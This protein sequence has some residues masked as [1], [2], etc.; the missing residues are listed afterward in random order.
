MLAQSS[1]ADNDGGGDTL[2]NSANVSKRVRE[3]IG[4]TVV[5]QVTNTK[6]RKEHGQLSTNVC[7]QV[8]AALASQNS[9][10]KK[11]LELAQ[12]LAN[13]IATEL[14]QDV[15]RVSA[16]APG[17]VNF[18]IEPAVWQAIEAAHHKQQQRPQPPSS[19]SSQPQAEAPPIAT[20]EDGLLVRLV[21]LLSIET[22]PELFPLM[23]WYNRAA[24]VGRDGACGIR[25]GVV[26]TVHQVREREC[27]SE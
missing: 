17:F 22:T 12:A 27:M 6:L 19:A 21:S 2:A 18:E 24:V 7:L 25:P 9:Y 3:L 4:G 15:V 1:S 16:T 5:R 10:H 11:P 13:T 14:P 23:D 8:A 26:R 20:L